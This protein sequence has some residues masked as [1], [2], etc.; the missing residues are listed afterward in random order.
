MPPFHHPTKCRPKE[1][2]PSQARVR[3]PKKKEVRRMPFGASFPN[4]LHNTETDLE[5]IRTR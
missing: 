1:I 4:P 2:A 3:N 5:A